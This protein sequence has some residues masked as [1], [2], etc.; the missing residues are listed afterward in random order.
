VRRYA[1]SNLVVALFCAFLFFFLLRDQL[2]LIIRESAAVAVLACWQ[3]CFLL[4]VLTRRRLPWLWPAARNTAVVLFVVWQLFFLLV[5]NPLDF[6]YAPLKD[7]CQDRQ[8]WNDR[9]G[10]YL[11]RVDDATRRYGNFDGID[12]NW[13]MFTPPLTRYAT[14]LAVRIEFADG[15]DDVL[16]SE[17]EPDPQ[18]FFRFGGWR[19]RKLE[20]VLAYK[21][22]KD[23]AGDADLPLCEAYVRWSLRRWQDAHPDDPRT[24]DRVVLLRRDIALPQPGADASVFAPADVTVVGAFQPDGSLAP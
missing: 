24:P 11:D 12:Q 9:I 16:L 7:W 21:Q 23:L 4:C 17:N 22:P 20:D 5:R 2:S 3:L 13:R 19:Q 1:Q 18:R 8:I 15:P 10:P 14:F 6:W